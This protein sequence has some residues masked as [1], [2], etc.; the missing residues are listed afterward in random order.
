LSPVQQQIKT[1]WSSSRWLQ[2]GGD[3]VALS[4][5]ASEHQQ[6]SRCRINL[7]R[8]K[9][10]SMGDGDVCSCTTTHQDETS[11]QGGE[12][13]VGND[14]AQPH[15]PALTSPSVNSYYWEPGPRYSHGKCQTITRSIRA[16]PAV[17]L[18]PKRSPWKLLGERARYWCSYRRLLS[19][20]IWTNGVQ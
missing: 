17:T 18:E 13:G 7:Q 1:D 11:V 9:S 8:I 20:E 5:L 10:T 15:G 19:L 14:D 12:P 6:K 16:A 2:T 4:L 3:I